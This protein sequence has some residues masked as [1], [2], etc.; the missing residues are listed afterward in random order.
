MPKPSRFV[1]LFDE[2]NKSA[3]IVAPPQARGFWKAPAKI[4]A[5]RDDA[6]EAQYRARNFLIAAVAQALQ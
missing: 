1:P 4:I 6:S 3:E 5:Q 2:G